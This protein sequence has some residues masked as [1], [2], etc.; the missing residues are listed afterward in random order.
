MVGAQPARLSAETKAQ[1]GISAATHAGDRCGTG[2]V[3]SPGWLFQCLLQSMTA[4]NR[5]PRVLTR[6]CSNPNS[7]ITIS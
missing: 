3:Q 2:G 5:S 7:A 4:A 6:S 1:T